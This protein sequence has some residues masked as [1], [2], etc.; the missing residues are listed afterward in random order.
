[1]PK[2]AVDAMGGDRAPAVVVEGAWM[3]AKDLDVE[4][5]LVG[6]K[7]AI[8]RE[9]DQLNAGPLTIASASQTIEMHESASNALKKRDS[10]MK[11]AFDLMKTGEV[12]GV[13]S[14]GNSGAMMAMGMFV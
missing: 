3:A 13:V 11:I 9:L 1:M 2:I 6:E 12:Q 8:Q 10:S 14:A 4:V 7:Q 5:V